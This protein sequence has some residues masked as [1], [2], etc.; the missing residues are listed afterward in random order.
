MFCSLSN[1]PCTEP[2]VSKK[3]GHIFEKALLCKHLKIHHSCPI[4]SEPMSM[5]DVIDL[6]HSKIPSAPKQINTSSI[7]LLLKTFQNEWDE[8]MLESFNLKKKLQD[9][10][11]QL[12]HSLYQYDAAIRV[13]SRLTEE[14]DR[15]LQLIRF[16]ILTPKSL[17]YFIFSTYTQRIGQY[18]RVNGLR[19]ITN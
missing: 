1:E 19:T 15:A 5:D 9:T 12:S 3:T 16:Y 8:L 18:Q 13:I 10:R 2:V 6:K 17:H 11:Q 14:R 7:P 4:T